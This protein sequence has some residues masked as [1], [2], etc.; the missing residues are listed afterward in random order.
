M[1][2]SVQFLTLGCKVNQY[3]TEAI[4]EQF[5]KNGFI[6][7]NPPGIADI[8]VINT[9]TVTK[10]ADTKSLNFIRRVFRLNPK[11]K[12][13]VTGCLAEI[14]KNLISTISPS[15]LIAENSLKH[16]IIDFVKNGDIPQPAK[17]TSAFSSSLSI[18]GFRDYA[19]VFLKIQ[20]GCDNF[21]SYCKVPF[22]RGRSRSRLIPDIINEAKILTGKGF[23][24]IILTGICLGGWGK[25]LN[26]SPA[27]EVVLD[28]LES[29]KGDFRIRLSSIEPDN[30]QKSLVKKI[31][32]SKKICRHLHIPLQSGD[33]DIL[34]RMNRRYASE[35]FLNLVQFIKSEIPHIAITTD[36]IVGF[37]GEAD[38]N[39]KN[40]LK[41]VEKIA[42]LKVHIF[43]YS[44]RESTLAYNFSGAVNPKIIKERVKALKE[45]SD[46]ASLCYRNRFI[47]K[48]SDILIE[49]KVK[50]SHPEAPGYKIFEGYTDNYIHTSV[51]SKDD[52]T[53]GSIIPVRL[54]AISGEDAIGERV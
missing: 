23:R 9:C 50:K 54:T 15:I 44:R 33:D 11:A 18:S 47:G 27:L 12:I 13:V 2:L 30:I 17:E 28:E 4:R 40:T 45:I 10:Q 46:K 38:K 48:I 51:L 7:I 1:S 22:V 6:E 19:K 39:F 14:D 35:D 5:L 37:P 49:N 52:L 21:C 43:P 31:K 34:K 8:F 3:E 29:L 16:K 36:C 53:I 24:E 26:G 41:I 32:N 42:P 25:D 20:D